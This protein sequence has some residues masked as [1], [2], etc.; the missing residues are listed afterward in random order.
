MNVRVTV[1]NHFSKLTQIA[2]YDI[3][4]EL[5]RFKFNSRYV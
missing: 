1:K 3:Q 4:L 2:G 5:E